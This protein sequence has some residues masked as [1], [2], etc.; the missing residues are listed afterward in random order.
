MESAGQ[1]R[2]S[3]FGAPSARE[4]VQPGLDILRAAEAAPTSTPSDAPPGRPFT[5]RQ[6]WGS[7]KR[8]VDGRIL[9]PTTQ[10]PP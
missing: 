5:L 9:Y 1:T 8:M 6:T 4:I 10:H 2:F 3:G 7:M